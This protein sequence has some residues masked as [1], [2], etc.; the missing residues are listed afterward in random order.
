MILEVAEALKAKG[1]SEKE[2]DEEIFSLI[3]DVEMAVIE[4]ILAQLPE[5]K[6]QKLEEM[7]K[8]KASPEAIGEM[9]KLDP[10]KTRELEFEKFKELSQKRLSSI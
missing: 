9:L 2:I 5:D 4:A 3:T 10:E 1:K 7:S 8:D 6:Q